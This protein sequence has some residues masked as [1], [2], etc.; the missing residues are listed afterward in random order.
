V[1]QPCGPLW[2]LVNAAVE[3]RSC[4]QRH[5]T[6]LA[7]NHDEGGSKAAG[8]MVDPPI[9]H[10]PFAFDQLEFAS[11]A[12]FYAWMGPGKSS[13]IKLAIMDMWNPNNTNAGCIMRETREAARAKGTQL[14]ILK[15]SS[16]QARSSPLLS[17]AFNGKPVRASSPRTSRG[18]SGGGEPLPARSDGSR[19]RQD[20]A[21]SI[22]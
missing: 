17:P 22:T 5:K 9:D 14:H 6:A 20:W 11:M 18:I 1:A 19:I 16:V 7:K 10:P 12:L 15:A 21:K 13:K 2:A 8:R 3:V 4:A